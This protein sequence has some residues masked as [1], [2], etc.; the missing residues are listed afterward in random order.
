MDTNV[1]PPTD[2]ILEIKA[3]TRAYPTWWTTEND[4]D[5]SRSLRRES[6]GEVLERNLVFVDTPGYG[7]SNDVFTTLTN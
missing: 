4:I 5:K 7:S 6:V 2:N 3:S 1:I